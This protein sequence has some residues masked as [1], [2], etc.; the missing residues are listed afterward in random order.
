MHTTDTSKPLR[1]LANLAQAEQTYRTAHDTH[2]TGSLAAGQAWDR[3]RSA[4]YQAR[5]Y[6]REVNRMETP[7]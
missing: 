4:G 5:Q 7:S 2:G 3:M 1:L 6:L